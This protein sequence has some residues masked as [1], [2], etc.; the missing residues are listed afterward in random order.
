MREKFLDF[1]N[2]LCNLNYD[3]IPILNEL[4]KLFDS[5]GLYHEEG[6]CCE[7]IYNITNDF[8]LYEKIGDIFLYKA[9]NKN[10]AQAAYEEFLKYK[11]PDFYPKYSENMKQLGYEFS[12]CVSED[13]PKELEK[14]Y[15]RY[16]VI[17]YMMVYLY[18]KKEYS[19]VEQLYK[20]LCD[21]KNIINTKIDKNSSKYQEELT[22]TEN[23]LSEIFSENPDIL[24]MNELAV[25]LSGNNRRAYLNI[26]QYYLK[27]NKYEKALNYYNNIYAEVFEL[28]NCTTVVQICWDIS[29]YYRSLGDYYNAVFYQKLGIEYKLFLKKS[30]KAKR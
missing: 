13:L 25:L 19:G 9:R 30:G 23:H 16:N 24:N 11:L 12:A 4:I 1:A 28:Q 15:D 8:S 14:L 21:I 3:I 26:I 20:Y 18:K 6:A 22:A 10:I 17:A 7:K 2:G 27:K 29:E 5:A